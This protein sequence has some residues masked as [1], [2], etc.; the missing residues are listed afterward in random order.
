MTS[1]DQYPQ[2]PAPGAFAAPGSGQYP[3]AAAAPYPVVEGHGAGPGSMGQPEPGAKAGRAVKGGRVSALWIGVI[4]A[5]VLLIV[6]LVF[7]AQ[8]SR[9]VTVRF[10]W[11]DG[12]MPLAIAILLSAVVGA[13][14]VAAPGTARIVQLR[15]A[16]RHA[17]APRD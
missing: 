15:R 3:A 2:Q 14:L 10:L 5:A 16:V 8:N 7:I 12:H 13:L 6:L 9:Q 4:A 1:S 11:L 17:A